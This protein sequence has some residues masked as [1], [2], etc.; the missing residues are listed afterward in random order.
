[1]IAMVDQDVQA[2]AAEVET[3][4]ALAL[5]I[6]VSSPA[7]AEAREVEIADMEEVETAILEAAV[8]EA[9][10]EA[11]AAVAVIVVSSVN[12]ES[13]Y[14]SSNS[15]LHYQQA[16]I[17]IATEAAVETTEEAMEEEAALGTITL[18]LDPIGGRIKCYATASS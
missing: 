6:I 3:D 15:Q 7:A 16:T 9:V 12:F 17:T 13:S 11:A 2:I 5:E 8:E 10:E 1:M 18:A 14:K 4:T